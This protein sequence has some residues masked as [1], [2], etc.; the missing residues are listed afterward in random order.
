MR[1]GKSDESSKQVCL[2]QTRNNVRVVLRV[3]GK[4]QKGRVW[5]NQANISC[6]FFQAL[7]SDGLGGLGSRGRRFFFY[8]LDYFALAFTPVPHTL[9]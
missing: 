9:D 8:M 1:F 4:K 6:L 2:E 7:A 3:C 5:A